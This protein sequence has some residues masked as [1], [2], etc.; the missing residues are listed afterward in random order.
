[1]SKTIIVG[2]LHIGGQQSM[3]K[4][5]IGD[6]I[7]SRVQDQLK[8][9]NFIHNTAINNEVDRIILTGDIFHDPK[10]D[11]YLVLLFIDW[12]KQCHQYNI[13]VHIVAGNHDFRRQGNRFISILDLISWVEL[14]DVSI[15][16]NINTIHTDGASYTFLPFRDRRTL[17]LDSLSKAIDDFNCKLIYEVLEI[18]IENSKILVGHMALEGSIYSNEIDELSNEIMC[19]LDMFEKYD[20]V[21]MGHVHKP[22]VLCKKPH[23]AHIGSMDIS[24]SSEVNHKKIIILF[25]PKSDNKFTEIELPTRKVFRIKLE[26][27]KEENPTSYLINYINEK[28]NSNSFNDSLV[29][30]E[31]KILDPESIQLDR[32]LVKSHLEKLGVYNVYS[33]IE[34]RASA[35]ISLEKKQEIESKLD[36]KS[37]LQFYSDNLEFNSDQ[38]K[39]DFIK[40]A[41]DII[42][43]VGI[44]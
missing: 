2:D 26:I 24:D 9:L 33:F 40:L 15:H 37:S 14:P 41:I 27:P 25:D 22:Q 1:M 36:I 30:I 19:P 20:Y 31:V 18:P 4:L 44:N 21:W 8:L 3:A 12:L 6:N 5:S 42:D 13:E 7:N 16:N 38:E 23:I 35:L 29:K 17:D 43:E 32:D 11:N 10:P 39:E 28:N 34:T